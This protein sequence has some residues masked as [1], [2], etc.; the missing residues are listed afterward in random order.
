MTYTISASL[1]VSGPG[2]FSANLTLPSLTATAAGTDAI[3]KT[4]IIG[5]SSEQIDL[6][7]LASAAAILMV[8]L[9]ETNFVEV[10]SANTY[11]KFPQKIKPG[12]AILLAPETVTIHAKADTNPVAVAYLA[13]EL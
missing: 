8:N 2:G 3:G 11:D 5:T 1:A 13:V 6:G 4:Q 9:D 10:D 7:E 12:R